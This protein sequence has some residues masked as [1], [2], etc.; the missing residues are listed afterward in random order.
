MSAPSAKRRRKDA[1]P[2]PLIRPDPLKRVPN[3]FKELTI[4]SGFTACDLVIVLKL[5]IDLFGVNFHFTG[6]CEGSI[7]VLGSNDLRY[8]RNLWISPQEAA[9]PNHGIS[10]ELRF[11]LERYSNE[12]ALLRILDWFFIKFR[13]G[14]SK[15]ITFKITDTRDAAVDR[16]VATYTDE[17]L[18]FGQFTSDEVRELLSL[19]L[20]L[21][22][23]ANW[24]H[25]T[26]P[27]WFFGA[28]EGLVVRR[29]QVV[30]AAKEAAN[31][32]GE[33]SE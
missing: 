29:V 13:F 6:P 15:G 17:Y 31:E 16:I 30:Q 22:L 26:W 7:E 21:I 12:S 23:K 18:G 4:Q 33:S 14:T 10:T 20:P 28:F 9:K 19:P 3:S 1:T 11:S 8:D 27:R 5:M 2:A 25:Y 24:P 32:A